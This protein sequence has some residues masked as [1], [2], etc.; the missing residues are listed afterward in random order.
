MAGADEMPSNEPVGGI[1]GGRT[2]DGLGGK[3][4][5]APGAWAWGLCW[6][7]FASTVL[8]YMDRQAIALVGPQI[9]AQYALDNRGFGWVLASFQLTYAFFQWP[10][11]YLVDRWNVRRTYAGAVL[12]WSFAGIATAF[13]PSLGL[14]MTLRAMLGMGES[15]NWPCALRVTSG[16]LPPSDRSLGNGIFNSGAAIG[17]V[18]TPLF[19]TPL[20]IWMGW[21]YPFV[22]LGL[23]GLVWVAAWLMLTKSGGLA[24]ATPP[25]SVSTTSGLCSQAMMGFTAVLI[26]AVATTLS[27]WLLLPA[28]WRGAA[29]WWGVAVFM[30]GLLLASLAMPQEWLDG[31]DW[32]S[33]LGEIVRRRRFWVAAAVGIT[34]NVTW[35][36][37]VNWM[38]IFFQEQRSLGMLVGGMVSALPFLAADLGNLGGGVLIRWL[39]R[40]GLTITAARKGVMTICLLLVSCAVWVGF[41][42][43]EALVIALLCLAAMGAAA[44]MVNYFAFGQDVTPSHTGLVI[45]YLGGL[46]NLFAAGFMPVAGWISQGRSGFTPNF[47]IVGLL[48]LAGL[49]ALLVFWGQDDT[50]PA[51]TDR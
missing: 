4:V 3:A 37:L 39:T 32:A 44:Y 41:V 48:P 2:G 15:F 35:H 29:V 21:R 11:G 1:D 5:N 8:N 34:I 19:V 31:A 27:G 23:G 25:R 36:F 46:G 40:H 50:K 47:V 17:A 13:A 51:W 22:I 6:L 12:W 14:L 49:A 18:L 28:S 43:S 26:L 10:A 16:V 9:K 7:M 45:G 38:A 20:A 30:I 42:Q 24:N 33:S